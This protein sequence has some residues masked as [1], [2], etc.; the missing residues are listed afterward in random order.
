MEQRT[1]SRL[2]WSAGQI[3]AAATW[4]I[5][6]LVSKYNITRDAYDIAN[7]NGSVAVPEGKVDRKSCVVVRKGGGF[8]VWTCGVAK[9]HNVDRPAACRV[10]SSESCPPEV[11]ASAKDGVAEDK[12]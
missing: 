12:G 9:A 10:R 7:E 3:T 11:R 4:V 5:A 8:I 1:P 2:S 6:K